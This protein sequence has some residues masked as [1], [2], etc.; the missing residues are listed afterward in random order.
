[1][2]CKNCYC[3]DCINGTK[4]KMPE[5]IDEDLKLLNKSILPGDY[6]DHL[7]TATNFIYRNFN[8]IAPR[9]RWGFPDYS[10][11]QTEINR[12]CSEISL[13]GNN[14]STIEEDSFEEL[15]LQKA[16]EGYLQLPS[17]Y[18]NTEKLAKNDCSH[19]WKSYTG[20][21]ETYKYCELC[22]AKES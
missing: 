22:D 10:M 8:T 12:L 5:Y 14:C 6:T 2:S 3:S 9:K 1:M 19:Q 20:L 11:I 16:F 21:S 15:S 4:Y 7:Y 17:D 18:T 13:Y